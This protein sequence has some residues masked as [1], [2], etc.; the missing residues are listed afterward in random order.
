MFSCEVPPYTVRYTHHGSP[1][2]NQDDVLLLV[3]HFSSYGVIT[4]NI[5]LNVDV[6]EAPYE[7]FIQE[8]R[9]TPLR[10]TEYFGYTSTITPSVLQFRY[11]YY[12]GATCTVSLDTLTSGWPKLGS[13]VSTDNDEEV[14][15]VTHDCRD[16][17]YLGLRY[18]HS[19]PP[20]PD[21]DYLPLTVHLYDPVQSEDPVVERL[22]LPIVITGAYPNLA[23]TVIYLDSYVMEIS[24]YAIRTLP[25]ESL[26]AKDSETPAEEL[27]FNISRAP[28]ENGGHFVHRD[29][30]K[31]QIYSFLQRDLINRYDSF[32]LLF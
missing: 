17:L 12:N 30:P 20:T 24:Q 19:S 3:H 5:Y 15:Q 18:K 11:N 27:I 13:L 2:K 29:E 8:A 21:L 31:K 22:F 9:L 26:S 16:F 25:H 4:E 10:V 23:P 32:T 28:P 7:V 1:L 14:T 6:V